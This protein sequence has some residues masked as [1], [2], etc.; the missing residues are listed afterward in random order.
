MLEAALA[1]NE[2]IRFKPHRT[3]P[4]MV[5]WR[6][7]TEYD[8]DNPSDDEIDDLDHLLHDDDDDDEYDEGDEYNQFIMMQMMN[9]LVNGNAF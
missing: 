2:R 5:G 9:G 1:Q 3:H 7:T 8:V 4:Q 6:E